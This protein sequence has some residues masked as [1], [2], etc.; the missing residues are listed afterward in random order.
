M[1]R[2]LEH[3]SSPQGEGP[4]VGIMSQ[5]VRFAG[6]NL[7][8]EGWPCDT[9]HAIQPKLFAKEQRLVA[10]PQMVEELFEEHRRTGAANVV[11]TGGE[12]LL[13]N[14]DDLCKVIDIS[15]GMFTF[16]MF[17]NGTQAIHPYLA[18][19]C[20]FVVDW[21]LAGSGEDAYDKERIAN[22][23]RLDKDTNSFKF[24]ILNRQD[25]LAAHAVYE[26]FLKERRA[27]VFAGSVWDKYSNVA[28]VDYI[29]E[30][31]LPWRLNVQV[32]NYVFGAQKRFT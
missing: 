5:F 14:H 8:C 22:L 32:H 4:R 11:F 17:T 30:H 29:K 24:T 20:N 19:C 13:Q 7:R 28:I 6:C 12:P 9:Q 3:Y 10:I 15:E 27:Q 2:L 23:D 26:E 18:Q 16:E 31:Q 25:L 1:L 21:K